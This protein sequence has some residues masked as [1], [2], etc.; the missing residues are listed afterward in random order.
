MILADKII[1]ERKKNGWSQEELAEKLSVS[2]QSISKWEGAQS[3]PD[4]QKIIAMAQIFGVSTDYL[5]KDEIEAD[6]A[7]AVVDD[8]AYPENSQAVLV[9]MEEANAFIDTEFSCIPRRANAVSLCI[10]G[11][12]ILLLCLAISQIPGLGFSEDIMAGVGVVAILMLVAVAVFVFIVDGA[13][14]KRFEYLENSPIET[15]YGVTG[16]VMDKKRAF[17]QPCTTLTALG[18]IICIVSPV[19]LIATSLLGA[20][21]YTTLFMVSLL[22]VMVSFA[23]NLLVRAGAKM[24]AFKKLLQEE[25]YS[26]ANKKKSPFLS[27]VSGIYWMLATAIFLGVSFMTDGWDRT[28]IIWPVAGVLFP[29]VY[30]IAMSFCKDSNR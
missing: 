3:V 7:P 25:D 17:E 19:P 1:N 27:R 23:V 4:I 8:I 24:D 9:S 14:L 15:M 2:R 29:V 16:M 20:P 11:P 10:L 6:K 26:V 21:E 28:W 13:K 12:A 30:M 22:L 18:V 5:L